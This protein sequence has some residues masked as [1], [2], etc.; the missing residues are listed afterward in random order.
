MIICTA[1]R[2]DRQANCTA[3][4]YV[5]GDVSRDAV[6]F[7]RKVRAAGFPTTAGR[8]ARSLYRGAGLLRFVQAKRDPPP[9]RVLRLLGRDEFLLG[10][11]VV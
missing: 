8:L 11:H 2:Y 4:W 6:R 7:N 9:G 1:T 5:L 10:P 3:W